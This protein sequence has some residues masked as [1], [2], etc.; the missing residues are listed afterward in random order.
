MHA[1]EATEL[2]L[3]YEENGQ[4]CQAKCDCDTCWL[5]VID[6]SKGTCAHA[7]IQ[8]AFTLSRILEGED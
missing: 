6:L 5:N 1:H 3:K 8:D 7:F 4:M 2:S